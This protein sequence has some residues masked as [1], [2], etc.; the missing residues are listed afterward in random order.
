MLIDFSAIGIVEFVE[1]QPV[2]EIL[3]KDGSILEFL[4]KKAPCNDERAPYGVQPEVLDNYIRSVGMFSSS[5]EILNNI[6]L[7]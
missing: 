4:R 5:E 3:G 2:R 6:F 7:S 1:S